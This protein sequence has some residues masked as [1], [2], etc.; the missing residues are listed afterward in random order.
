VRGGAY[1]SSL[2]RNRNVNGMQVTLTPAE[3]LHYRDLL[4]NARY[5]TLA[6]AEGFES[7]CFAVERLGMRLHG[8]VA[9]MGTYRASL[10]N[11][12]NESAILSELPVRFPQLFVPFD[13]L[14]E[15]IRRARNDAMHTG[16]YARSI[17]HKAIEL[18]LGLEDAVM[19][20]GRMNDDAI[21]SHFMVRAPIVVEGWQ[22]VAQARQLMLTYSISYLPLWKD[23]R[24]MLLS[25]T[26]LLRYLR[27]ARTQNDRVG[28]PARLLQDADL[29]LVDAATVKPDTKIDEL[30]SMLPA[31]NATKLW[32]VVDS[33]VPQ[34]LLGVFTPFDLL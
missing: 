17:T 21:V 32:L 10:K 6:D 26:S 9:A 5:E 11:L 1:L 24:W 7:I 33:A 20:N 14:F 8:Q 30:L 22:P 23:E 4:R 3:R 29:D 2:Y 13:A 18:C 16:V 15:A 19:A 34:R 25:E 12:A 27:S 31:D 28:F